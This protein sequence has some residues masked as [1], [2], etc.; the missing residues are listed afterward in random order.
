MKLA[1]AVLGLTM[2]WQ[3][4]VVAQD[5]AKPSAVANSPTASPQTL[6][7]PSGKGNGA[8]PTQAP[9]SIPPNASPENQQMDALPRKYVEMWNTGDLH[10]I[11][12]MFST[13]AFIT[14]HG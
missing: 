4:S 2:L 12:T 10:P 14:F 6:K 7:E 9:A 8:V 1:P 11:A 13:P 3:S 5:G